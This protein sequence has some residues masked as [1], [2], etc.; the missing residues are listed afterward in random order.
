MLVWRSQQQTLMQQ[1]RVW[2]DVNVVVVSISF[3]SR[4]RLS[5]VG[6]LSLTHFTQDT[7][8]GNVQVRY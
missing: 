6:A 5:C 3:K 7:L 8:S 1:E 2:G 4:C